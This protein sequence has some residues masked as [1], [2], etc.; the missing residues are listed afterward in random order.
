[1]RGRNSGFAPSLP[2]LSDHTGRP[3]AEQGPPQPCSPT[4]HP[5]FYFISSTFGAPIPPSLCLALLPSLTAQVL[6][7][8]SQTITPFMVCKYIFPSTCVFVAMHS[9]PFYSVRKDYANV[10]SLICSSNFLLFSLNILLVCI[11]VGTC[12]SS[13]CEP[14]CSPL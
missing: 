4:Q 1:M 9:I 10:L 6:A 2:S 13:S 3:G 12:D 8:M 7:I 14:L 5:R 11:H